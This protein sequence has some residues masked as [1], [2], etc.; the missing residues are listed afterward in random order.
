MD[1]PQIG[2][3]FTDFPFGSTGAFQPAVVERGHPAI[4]FGAANIIRWAVMAPVVWGELE[5][6][7]Q[8][9]ERRYLIW[10]LGPQLS[11]GMLAW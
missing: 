11:V 9:Q 6:P 3:S 1:V 10:P 7:L 4:R 8:V 5:G 2:E